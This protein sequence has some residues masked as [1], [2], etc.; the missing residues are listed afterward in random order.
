MNVASRSKNDETEKWPKN[1]LIDDGSASSSSFSPNGDHSIENG[2]SEK[3]CTVPQTSA[4]KPQTYEHSGNTFA[5]SMDGL[6]SKLKRCR[7]LLNEKA[8]SDCAKRSSNNSECT[9]RIEPYKD[10]RKLADIMGLITKDLSEPYS[11]YT[12]RYFIHNWPELCLLVSLT[13]RIR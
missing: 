7:S 2:V 5:E 1:G 12:Y 10:E 8:D 3:S 11:I 9:F 13:F 4:D 6:I